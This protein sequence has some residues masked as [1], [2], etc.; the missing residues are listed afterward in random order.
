MFSPQVRSKLRCDLG[1]LL[2]GRRPRVVLHGIA[3]LCVRPVEREG[4]CPPR[5]ARGE[6]DA[7][8]AAFRVAEERR[9]LAPGRVHDGTHV[10]HARLEVRQPDAA[11]G[12]PRASLVEAD[13][14][15][16]RPEPLEEVGVGR[17]L[18]VDLEVGEEPLDEYEVEGAV[19]G[20]LVGDVH[21]A[22]ARVPDRAAH[23]GRIARRR[24]EQVSG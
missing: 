1:P 3:A 19:A 22:A 18:P 23:P 17:A 13:Q 11:V 8:R 16:E 20:D 10:V 6:E 21:L 5:I 2:P 24:E 9:G 4:A 15:C 7:Q 12:E 14:P